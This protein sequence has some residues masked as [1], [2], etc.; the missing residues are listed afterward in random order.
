MYVNL[1]VQTRHILNFNKYKLLRVLC[2]FSLFFF[3][4]QTLLGI[5]QVDVL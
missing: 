3:R 5:K 1:W 4:K 2:T